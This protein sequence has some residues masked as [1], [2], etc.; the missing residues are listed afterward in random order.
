MP[1]GFSKLESVEARAVVVLCLCGTVMA[2]SPPSLRPA[3]SDELLQGQLP[4][5]KLPLI[6][7]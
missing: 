4:S 1:R 7:D 2:L 3:P 5:H 6:W